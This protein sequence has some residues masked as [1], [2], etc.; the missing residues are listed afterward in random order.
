MDFWS[1]IA[2]GIAF[3]SSFIPLKMALT[4]LVFGIQVVVLLLGLHAS[5]CI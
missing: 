1:K 4:F 3:G 2:A 5:N